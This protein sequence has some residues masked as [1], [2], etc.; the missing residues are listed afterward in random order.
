MSKCSRC[1]NLPAEPP[2]KGVLYV[3]PPMA[4]TR[5]TLR[6]LL[7]GS[8]LPFGDPLEDVLAV[9]VCP[10]GLSRLGELL[11]EGLSEAELRD[12]RAILVEKGAR[13][14]LGMLPRMQDLFTL[15]SSAQGAWLK[16]IVREDGLN[17]HFQPIVAV[18]D[19]SEVFA[20]ECLLRGIGEGGAFIG[21]EPMF[22]TARA[23]G[24][25]HNLDRA[26]RVKAIREAAGQGI[27]EKV[28]VNFNATSIYDPAYCLRS[29]ME[30]V[31][32][33]GIPSERIV[34][35][36]TDGEE[37][38]DG[39]HLR[40]IVDYYRKGGFGVALDDLGS[41]YGSLD[42]LARLRPDFVKLD[43]GLVSRP[44][45]VPYKASIAREL[46]ELAN[47]LGVT[48]IAEG[49]ETEDQYLWPA[50]HG[51]DYVQGHLFARPAPLPTA[52]TRTYS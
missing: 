12:C 25:I 44:G 30:A 18:L 34:F 8:D 29:T 36:V 35:E 11:M 48:V 24:L 40:S 45:G 27:E 37:V 22:A 4:H 52:P 7:W 17:V 10:R 20:Y 50:A 21:P 13:V 42:L 14:D 3:A 51:A 23:A 39:V 47:E 46:I 32:E 33:S 38:K 16:K 41:G 49:V 19:P 5:G 9:E 43:M 26:A 15:L 1:E 31:E 2:E 6:R 28:F